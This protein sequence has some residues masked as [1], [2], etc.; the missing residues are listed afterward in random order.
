MGVIKIPGRRVS[1]P[2]DGLCRHVMVPPFNIAIDS[3]FGVRPTNGPRMFSF[4]H[5]YRTLFEQ[6]TET[7]QNCSSLTVREILSKS[8]S[9]SPSYSIGTGGVLLEYFILLRGKSKIAKEEKCNEAEQKWFLK[10]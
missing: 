3:Y 10:D 8:E 5:S 1:N 4:I 6:F 7:L 2:R 9:L